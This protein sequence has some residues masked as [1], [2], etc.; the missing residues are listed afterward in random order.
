M[1]TAAGKEEAVQGTVARLNEF[2]V[3]LLPEFIDEVSELQGESQQALQAFEIDRRQTA[4]SDRPQEKNLSPDLSETKTGCQLKLTN[5]RQFRESYPAMARV[6]RCEFM[7]EVA[8]LVLGT[9]NSLNRHV[10][11]T[12][13]FRP[14]DE[15]FPFHFDEMNALKFY[16]YLTNAGTGTA[17]LEVIPGTQAEGRFIRMSEWHRVDDFRAI[18]NRVFDEFSEEYFY[19]VFRR[20]K[21]VV[22]MD[23]V[24][25]GGPPGTLVIFNTDCLHRGGPLSS[26][27]Q[28]MVIRGSTY[29]GF[30]GAG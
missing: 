30:W 19:N 9:P 20:F 5:N 22:R 1:S 29:A 2:G 25:L 13:D 28:R 4:S 10:V 14:A 21:A 18:R 15:T 16:I 27:E 11:L 24:A 3:A 17:T 6:F 7:R 12:H 23:A 8:D 26:G